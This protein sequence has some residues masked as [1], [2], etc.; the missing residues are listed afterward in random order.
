LAEGRIVVFNTCGFDVQTNKQACL[1][2]GMPKGSHFSQMTLFKG[3]GL[4]G[5]L[6]RMLT[7]RKKKKRLSGFVSSRFF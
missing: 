7:F 1:L 3:N 2:L 4:V 5:I 6:K